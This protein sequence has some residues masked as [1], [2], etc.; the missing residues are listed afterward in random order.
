MAPSQNHL[1]A[2]VEIHKKVKTVMKFKKYW[3]EK[4]WIEFK[5]MFLNIQSKLTKRIF[6]VSNDECV[7]LNGLNSGRRHVIP[8]TK[9]HGSRPIHLWNKVHGLIL[10]NP[11]QNRMFNLTYSSILRII[12]V[13]NFSIYSI[14]IYSHNSAWMKRHK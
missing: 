3:I 9:I 14:G 7:L 10:L 2:S 11:V 13:V 5:N 6:Q 1:L 8:L 12:R 4:Y